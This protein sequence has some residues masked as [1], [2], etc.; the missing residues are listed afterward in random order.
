[1]KLLGRIKSKM[2]FRTPPLLSFPVTLNRRNIYILPTGHGILFIAVLGAMLIG[3]VNYNNNLGFLLTF[4]LGGMTF[5]SLFYTVK[6]LSGL[7]IL[8]AKARPVFSGE[9]AAFEFLVKTPLPPRPMIHF[10]FTDEERRSSRDLNTGSG[11][12]I[13]VRAKTKGR[14]IYRPGLLYIFTRYPLGL[15]RAWSRLHLPVDCVVYPR[16]AAGPLR[17]VEGEAA[18]GENEGAGGPGAEDFMGLRTYQP[19]DTLQQI[20]WK[21]YSRGQGLFTKEFVGQRG[22]SLFFDWSAVPEA[23]PEIRLSRLCHMVLTASRYHQN[24]GLLLPGLRIEPDNSESHKHRCLKA[25][26]LFGIQEGRD[27]DRN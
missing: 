16:P 17:S 23:D 14:G 15:F 13:E 6:N 9:I 26:A 11:Q 12:H 18:E 8:S 7:E 2:K 20:D 5:I 22:A 10:S 1:M 25:L 21:A 3:S 19:G 4:L 27:E 24:Y